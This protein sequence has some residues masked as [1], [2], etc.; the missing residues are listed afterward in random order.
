VLADAVEQERQEQFVTEQ[1]RAGE[2]V[3]G[4]YPLAGAWLERYRAWAAG[5]GREEQP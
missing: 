5:S 2:S 1:V 3:D 4:L